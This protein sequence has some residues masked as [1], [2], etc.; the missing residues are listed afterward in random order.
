MLEKLTGTEALDA[1]DSMLESTI[2]LTDTANTV[3]TGTLSATN[4]NLNLAAGDRIALK[5]ANDLTDV[6]GL[7]VI[8]ELQIT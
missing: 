4:A 2:D 8:V 7:S 3:V 6:A 1:G 5:D